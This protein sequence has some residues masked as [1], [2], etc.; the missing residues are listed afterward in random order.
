MTKNALSSVPGFKATGIACGIKASGNK[1]LAVILADNPS[2]A[3]TMFTT[4]SFQAAPVLYDKALMERTK[5]AG[6]RAILVNAGNA[7]ACTGDQGD[8]DAEQMS[9]WLEEKAGLPADSVF[10]M[11]TGIIG[12]HLP[13]DII[14]A[15]VADALGTLE[16]DPNGGT[17][18]A[19]AIM[20]TDT[21]SKESFR[22]VEIG[23]HTVSIGGVAK[24]SGMIH[25]DMAT[26]LSAVVTD[27]N[28]SQADLDTA[29]RTAVNASFNRVTVDGDTSTNDTIVL[30]ANGQANDVPLSGEDLAAFTETLTA[31]CVDL[32][33][34]IARDG[35]GATKLIE[36]QVGGAAS[37]EDAVAAARTIA[38]SPLVK[39]AI[40]GNDPNWGRF[41]MAIGRSGAQVDV[42]KANLWLEVPA[43]NN[44]V[45]LVEQGQPLPFDADTLSKQL[46]DASDVVV[47][48]DLGLGTG[49]STYWTCDFS[50]KYVEINAEYHT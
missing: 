16:N 41:V 40:F 20:T 25:P 50:Y 12:H 34:M 27:A 39:T 5:G 13:M 30:L 6:I 36:V 49:A 35:E 9:R 45:Q 17:H 11:S 26:M 31:L 29:L 19:E 2:T 15:G 44:K 46:H 47:Q 24:G 21:W 48:A 7:N 33:K 4:N 38:I 18:A 1:D 42:S 28:V 32:A 10:V 14:Q 3:A 43:A 37:D 8:Q 23:G 22:Q